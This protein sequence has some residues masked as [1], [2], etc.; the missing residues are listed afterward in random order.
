MHVTTRDTGSQ[1]SPQRAGCER[2]APHLQRRR[3][4]NRREI[5][6]IALISRAQHVDARNTLHIMRVTRGDISIERKKRREKARE[7]E[8]IKSS[9]N[10]FQLSAGMTRNRRLCLPG[11]PRLEGA[12]RIRDARTC[13]LPRLRTC[14]ASTSAKRERERIDRDCLG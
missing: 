4:K 10:N 9:R 7:R 14:D 11:F 3:R 5:Y 2:N 13:A 12:V 6:G 8:T 1:Y